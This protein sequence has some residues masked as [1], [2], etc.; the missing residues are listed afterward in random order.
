[1]AGGGLADKHD[2]YFEARIGDFQSFKSAFRGQLLAPE[3]T[4]YDGLL[5][6][7]RDA[8]FDVIRHFRDFIRTAPDELTAYVALLHG[9][10][11]APS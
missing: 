3:D 1:M 11:G 5:L 8:A 10:D 9:P 4:G 6:Y 7:A 2:L